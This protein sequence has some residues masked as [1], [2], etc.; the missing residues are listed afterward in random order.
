MAQYRYTGVGRDG[1]M[2]SGELAG[3]FG[4]R[5]RAV[6]YARKRVRVTK[7]DS[8]RRKEESTPCRSVW[9]HRAKVTQEEVAVYSRASSR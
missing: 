8:R 7:V 4:Q 9:P 6:S 2:T 3:R 5:C 1:G